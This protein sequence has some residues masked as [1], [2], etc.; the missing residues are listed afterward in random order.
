MDEEK[1]PVSKEEKAEITLKQTGVF[2]KVKLYF[3]MLGPGLITGASD[4][5]PSG[6]G[7]Y[8]QTGAQFG[9]AQLW[10]A[11]F[12]FPLMAGIQEICARITLH[13][14]RSLTELI[15][16]NYSRPILYF[17]VSL[18]FLANTFNLGADL[19][20]MA[21]AC[22]LVVGLP[23]IVWLVAI[24]VFSTLLQIFMDYKKYAQV[25]RYLTLSLLAYV[26][27]FFVTP[28]DWEQ[29]MRNTLIPSF[30][31]NK[32]YLL[33]LVAILGTTISPY[34]FFWQTNQVVE[35]E[36]AEGKV[37]TS[38]RKGVSKVELKWMR[39]DVVSGMLFS[40]VI[41][42]FIIATAASTFFKHG[43]TKVD[44]ALAAAKMLEP[45]AGRFASLVFAVG[46]VGTGLLAV[47]I[48]A[49]SAAYAVAETFKM[50]KGLYRKL[51]E[52][53]GF[54]GIL[55]IATL[56]G[57]LIDL[58]GIDPIKALYYAAVLNGLAA[59]PLLLMIMLISSNSGIMQDKVNTPLSAGLGWTTTVAMTIAALALLAS[60]VS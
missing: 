57:F 8:S 26:L 39:T 12:S 21:A 27:V 25:L 59:P 36:I 9:F 6:I 55:T 49:G 51:H 22:R 23:F 34:L 20:A 2:G 37:T 41:M 48:L 17:C 46:I 3:K 19:G 18:L 58:T 53:P 1:N 54:Y 43:F 45:I 42:W 29:V 35:E 31:F 47:P 5:D 11:V 24:T 16:L 38:A 4:D 33:N 13:T 10:T 15:C 30:E 56:T 7:T 32:D 14:G 28:T 44:S 50:R 40:N 60:L 52:A